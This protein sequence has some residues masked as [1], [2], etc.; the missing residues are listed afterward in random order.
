MNH[1]E[2]IREM[3][4]ERYLLNELGPDARDEFEE[5][6]FDCPECALE[7]RSGSVLIGEAKTQLPELIANSAAA[8]K[9]LV[10]KKNKNWIAWMRPA[11]AV[12]VMAALLV[13][14]GYQNL[15][16]LPALR[17]STHRPHIVQIAPL[18]GATRGG[19]HV[20]ID[21]DPAGGVALPIDL[22]VDS[23][24]G[25]FNSFAL[26]LSNPEG[27]VVWTTSLHAA[28]SPEADQQFSIVVPGGMLENGTYTLTV[29]GV[30]AGGARSEVGR[31]VF[32]VALSKSAR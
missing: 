1:S 3:V 22:P 28:Q 16:T 21:V 25:S 5:H 8:N 7:V 13:V 15:V 2:A 12:P 20:S 11:F 19:S 23:V 29:S 24:M 27:K 18:Y 14:V 17:S 32:D 10:E 6:M 26:E 30:A 31:Y 9:P 4:A